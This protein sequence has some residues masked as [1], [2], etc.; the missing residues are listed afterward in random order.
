MPSKSIASLLREDSFD[1]PRV[2]KR[3]SSHPFETKRN[4]LHK[5]C[6]QPDQPLEIIEWALKR[7]PSQILR[8]SGLLEDGRN[9][10]PLQLCF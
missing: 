3:A 10:T 8:E 6:L 4:F 2:K 9:L 1:W 5:L 7:Y